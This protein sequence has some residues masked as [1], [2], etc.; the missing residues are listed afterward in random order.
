MKAH[1]ELSPNGRRIDVFFR[2]SPEAVL[3]IKGDGRDEPGVP[4]YR[5]HDN[6]RGKYWSVPATM[7]SAKRLRDA[8]GTGLTLGDSVR[9]WGKE[10]QIAARRLARYAE[11]GDADL[12]NVPKSFAKWLR[13][14]QR[15]D[16]AHMAVQNVINAN[17]PGVGKTVETIAAIIESGVPGP[18][19][20]ICPSSLFKDP[21]R[22]ELEQHAPNYR[23]MYGDTPSQRKGAIN[24]AWMEF[25][26]GRADDLILLLNPEMVRVQKTL[27][28][29]DLPML[30]EGFGPYP[31][32]VLSRDHK[33]NAYTP[34]DPITERLFDIE[35]GWVVTD[36]FHKYG[37]GSDRN[38]QFARGLAALAQISKKR[39]ALSG[40]PTG[41]KSI[42]LWGPLNFIEPEAFSSKWRWAELWFENE[43]GGPIVAGAGDGI[44]GIQR[45][46]LDEFN[47]AHAAT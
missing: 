7:E 46:R 30:D 13:T 39:A 8:F 31:A 44:G 29:E 41:G 9:N 14:Y 6:K 23:V 27:Q 38:T 37:L 33:G 3:A 15:A 21:W 20:I 22:D 28:G 42:R 47:E 16:A 40:T 26:D 36:E 19:L 25:K 34:K 2:Y 35:W 1:C 5:F 43:D 10:Q 24:Y 4:G 11:S 32:P 12:V 18:H 17:Q 45:G